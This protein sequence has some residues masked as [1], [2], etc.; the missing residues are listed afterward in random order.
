MCLCI[1][2]VSMYLGGRLTPSFISVA[3]SAVCVPTFQREYTRMRYL[4]TQYAESRI[5]VTMKYV[6][7]R[8]YESLILH[9]RFRTAELLSTSTLGLVRKIE[10]GTFCPY[11]ASFFVRFNLI[12][13]LSHCSA[14]K[15][16]QK[17][18]LHRLS[19][20]LIQKIYI[21]FYE[22]SS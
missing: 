13:S 11:P 8:R 21:F 17:K 14:N 7:P 1:S 12:N 10:Y 22:V 18:I 3:G 16:N 6:A 5:C 4:L 9:T 19:S 20:K 2:R 15:T